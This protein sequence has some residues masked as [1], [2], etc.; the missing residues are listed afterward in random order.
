V[1][2]GIKALCQDITA[3]MALG[4]TIAGLVAIMGIILGATVIMEA[5]MVVAG[6]EV[7]LTEVAVIV[8]IFNCNLC[9]LWA[10]FS[11]PSNRWPMES[12]LAMA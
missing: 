3:G 1:V 8:E 4:F 7:V 10:I 12:N 6:M 5:I 9:N 11:Y 2:D